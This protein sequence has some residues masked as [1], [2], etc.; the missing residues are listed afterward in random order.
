MR[1]RGWLGAFVVGLALVGPVSASS[2]S[3]FGSGG[4]LPNVPVN[5]SQVAVGVPIARPQALTGRTG[6]KLR[7]YIPGFQTISNKR[8]I[9]TSTFPTAQQMPGTNY[10][11]AFKYGRGVSVVP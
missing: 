7:D 9:G 4:S 8:I 5:T 11:K 10:L 2:T 1:M 3:F 6:F